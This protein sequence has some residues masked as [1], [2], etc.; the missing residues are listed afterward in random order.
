M[1]PAQTIN[2]NY[3]LRHMRYA[4][5]IITARMRYAETFDP[6]VFGKKL[7]YACAK[8]LLCM[9][10]SKSGVSPVKYKNP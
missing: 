3:K 1:G 7:K 8:A 4:E 5:A 2:S 6:F 9:P 10:E